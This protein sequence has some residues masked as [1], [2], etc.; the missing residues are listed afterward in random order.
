V[1]EPLARNEAVT[2]FAH[3]HQPQ[4]P[5]TLR[6]RAVHA[7]RSKLFRDT[8]WTML[9]EI[10]G[11]ASQFVTL[12]L[13]GRAFDKSVFGQFAGAV[14]FMNVISPFTTVGM[15]YILLQRIAGEQADADL[16]AGRAWVTVTIGGL[17]GMV[18]VL[19]T[20]WIFL[21]Q[22]SIHVLVAL[23]LGELIFSQITYTGRFCAQAFDRPAVGAR[24][25][26]CVWAVRLLAA[27][28][29]L[30]VTPH[31]TLRGWSM[32]HM[33]ASLIGAV[34]MIVSLR[35]IFSLRP[36][37]SVARTADIR[38]GLA[39][40]LTIG[41][42]YLKN[43]AD[44]TL[45]VTFG[46]TEA[47]GL[48]SLAYRVITPLYV[49]VRALA[50]STFAR[51]F[52]EANTSPRDTYALAR[53]TTAIGA[54]LTVAGG[55]A[56]VAAAPLLP[57]ILSDKWRP[58]VV[59]TQWLAFVPCLV[60][61]Q[62]YAFNALISLGRRTACLVINV[63]ATVVNLALNVLLIPQYSWKGA[64]AATIVAEAG[65]VVALWWL[66]HREVTQHAPAR[67]HLRSLANADA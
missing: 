43:D 45:L 31:P 53:R 64:T 49:P 2:T 55:L 39:Y 33:S 18:F 9:A 26:A 8:G 35:R 21:P 51:F 25:V 11:M 44:K 60:A 7:I 22:L 12:V 66:L 61:M 5:V 65:S 16:Q 37:I 32:F 29:F 20:S 38:E 15:G 28:A 47:A 24:I 40:S 58:V 59:V 48:Y 19:A 56:I 13:I 50:D 14:A 41:A 27:I 10:A 42:A 23:A 62:M 67:D 63:A 30:V 17:V 34:I 3:P 46:K 52:R 1:T 4:H 36:R 6:G 54:A 57:F